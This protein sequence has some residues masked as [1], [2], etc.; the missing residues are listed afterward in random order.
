MPRD[1]RPSARSLKGLFAPMVSSRSFG[2]EPWI[3]ITAGNGPAPTGIV[4]VPGNSHGAVPTLTS[5]SAYFEASTYAGGVYGVA[6]AAAGRINRPVILPAEFIVTST[7]RVPFSNSQGT[8]T[9]VV[10]FC[11]AER[12][13]PR[14]LN[15]PACFDTEAHVA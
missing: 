9:R 5:R 13:A 11:S 4:N 3:R 2:P 14:R 10:P 1:A 8:T 7:S 15:A 12:A 6:V